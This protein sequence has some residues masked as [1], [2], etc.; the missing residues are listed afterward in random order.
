MNNKIIALLMVA[1]L[2]FGFFLLPKDDPTITLMAT[3][4]TRDSGL[5][6]HLIPELEKD[7][8]LKLR[9]I[10][11]STGKVLRSAREGNADIILVHDPIAEKAFMKE[12]YG[13]E[14]VEVM[15]N[16]FVIVGPDSDP[17]NVQFSTSAT[18]AFKNIAS[19]NAP[20]VSR[21]D[22]SGTHKAELRI[23]NAAG[24]E[25]NRFASERFIITG[26]GMGRSLNI[27]SE[28]S[29][30]ILTDRATWLTFQN[31]TNLKILYRGNKL[32]ENIYSIITVS[33]YIHSHISADTQKIILN[34]F[35]SPRA[36]NMIKNFKYEERIL[37]TP[38]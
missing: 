1:A 38:L 10:A 20:F 28:K 3:T 29:A 35:N 7:T 12:G 30:Y 27:A 33:H 31:K 8:G 4:T 25:N 19:S 11:F 23:F 2:T 14:R 5:L 24:I 16:D 22:E 6:D 9:V 18:Q 36:K 17:A 21:G 37:F 34:W 15:Q 26:A 32:L 13:S